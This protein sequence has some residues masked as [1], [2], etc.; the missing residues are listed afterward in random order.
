MRRLLD[1]TRAEWWFL[2][3]GTVG[4]AAS[5]AAM[6]VKAGICMIEG[7]FSLFWQP[8]LTP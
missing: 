7:L 4:A 5:G 2:L 3:P 8:G 6:P 1:F